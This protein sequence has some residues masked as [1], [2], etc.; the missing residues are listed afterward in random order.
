MACADL[1]CSHEVDELAY[2]SPTCACCCHQSQEEDPV[3][4]L[5]G[6]AM[7]IGSFIAVKKVAPPAK[8][9]WDGHAF[10]ALRSTWRTIT[11]S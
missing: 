1:T 8:R 7:L 5:I 11:W 3:A 9:L 2:L 6:S 4:A 10:P